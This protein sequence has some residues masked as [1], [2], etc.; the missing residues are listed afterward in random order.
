M[1]QQLGAGCGE[2]L[3]PHLEQTGGVAVAE[4]VVALLDRAL[5]SG[6]QLGVVLVQL[7]AKGVECLAAA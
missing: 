6:Q 3:V 2:R 5:V 7:Y 1:Q 4:Q